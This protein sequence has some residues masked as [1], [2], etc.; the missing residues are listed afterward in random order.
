MW[1]LYREIV[2][3]QREIYLAFGDRIDRFASTGDWGVLAG[4]SAVG[5]RVRGR[6][7]PDAGAQQGCAGDLPDRV[8]SQHTSR[9]GNL[10]GPVMRP[11]IHV[12]DH[13]A[14]RAPILATL[15]RGLLG[16][17]GL[18]ML[19]QGMRDATHQH[20][21][22][23]L[24]AGLIP[25][26]L[27]LFVMTF[28]VTRGVGKAGMALAVVMIVGVSLVLATVALAAV[29]FRQQL[30][31]LLAS[32]PRVVERVSRAI[33]VTAGAILVAIALN[34]VVGDYPTRG[35]A[36]IHRCLIV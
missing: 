24:A 15:S 23:G 9:S 26:P 33:Q 31:R 20:A 36:T 12:G 17:I 22:Q 10:A 8:D 16:L 11:C 7:C 30:L 13:R 19:W 21:G 34:V 4:L 6:P 27:T 32:R 35:Y 18:W 28:A 25:C 5:D 29:L 2:A 3:L 1:A 14:R